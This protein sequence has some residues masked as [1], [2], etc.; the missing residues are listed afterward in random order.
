[1][2]SGFIGTAF[3]KPPA[4][5]PALFTLSVFI[6]TVFSMR[7]MSLFCATQLNIP[8][9]AFAAAS[10]SE[11]APSASIGAF[12]VFIFVLAYLLVF[13]EEKLH[14]RKSLPMMFAAGLIWILVSL[15]FSSLGKAHEATN[16]LRHNLLEYAELMLFLLSAMTYINV[17]VER[18]VF[19]ALRTRLINLGLSLRSIFWI[20]GL[21]AFFLSP[22]ADNLTTA[23]I[24]GSVAL[25]IGHGNKAFITGTFVSIVVAANAGGAFSPFGDITT[26]MAWQK[27][28]IPFGQF[29]LLFLPSLANWLIPAAIISFTIPQKRLT[30][31][32]EFIAIKKGG[33]VVIGLFLL[34]IALTVTLYHLL[35]LPP[36]LGMMVGL[37]LLEIYSFLLRK[38]DSKNFTPENKKSFDSFH[39]L[40]NVEWDTL[41]FFYGIIL[42]VGGLGAIG[43]LE[44]VSQILYKG[45]GPMISNITIGALSSII[46]NIPVTFAVLSMNPIMD[47][48]QWLL[49]TLTVG[50]GGSLLSIGSAAGVA[51]MGLTKDY[52]FISHLKWSWAVLLGYAGSILV[53]LILNHAYFTAT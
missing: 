29:F 4:K 46:G 42:C 15:Y 49:F 3:T 53:H 20:T 50:V 45:L 51:L 21:L 9:F 41:L 48:G 16:L 36:F 8:P 40:K 34:N 26:L 37:S 31:Q 32:A 12:I 44:I 10:P 2:D 1:M 17:M 7:E 5:V 13:A 52:T 47:L 23:L 28:N 43:Y 19:E 38:N 22:I 11:M 27:G 6:A 30:V 35:E 25:A 39:S 24:M 14:L 18:N 33:G